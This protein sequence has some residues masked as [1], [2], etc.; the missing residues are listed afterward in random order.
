MG[1]HK[2]NLCLY[3]CVKSANDLPKLNVSINSQLSKTNIR[4]YTILVYTTPDLFI[5]VKSEIGK[6][7]GL[8]NIIKVNPLFLSAILLTGHEEL[9]KYKVC[10][11]NKVGTVIQ[12]TKLDY[13]NIIQYHLENPIHYISKGEVKTFNLH[14]DKIVRN[15]FENTLELGTD[16]VIDTLMGCYCSRV[17]RKNRLASLKQ[18]DVLHDISYLSFNKGL[19]TN[20]TFSNY[21]KKLLYNGI[22]TSRIP[23]KLFTDSKGY[24][25]RSLDALNLGLGTTNNY[26]S[27]FVSN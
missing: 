22:Y 27:L 18:A 23:F 20:P 10:I 26:S 21:I 8:T 24:I 4:Q 15:R 16:K 25:V 11:F 2:K 17:N 13:N 6:L 5:I 19:I 14:I 7:I 1:K 9:Y 12:G 3:Y